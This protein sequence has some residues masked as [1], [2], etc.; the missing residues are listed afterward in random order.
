MF[1]GN[2]NL[3]SIKLPK[4]I[5]RIGYEAF[6]YC[7]SLKELIIPNGVTSIQNGAFSYIGCESITIPE[8]VIDFGDRSYDGIDVVYC[9]PIDPPSLSGR[10]DPFND[11]TSVI[12]VPMESVE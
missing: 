6:Y 5:R 11:Y 8:N 12:Y 1:C 2:N 10:N 4:S 9:K 3:K 7:E